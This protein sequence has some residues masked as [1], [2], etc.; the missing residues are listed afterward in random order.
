MKTIGIRALKAHLSGIL[1]DVARGDVYLV[2][3][4]GRV[5]AELRS[6]DAAALSAT[7]EQLALARLAA[8]GQLRVAERSRPVYRRSP[9][10]AAEGLSKTLIDADRGE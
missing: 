6:P 9:I 3:D 2:T 1:R 10:N 4:R 5:V 8:R 7:P